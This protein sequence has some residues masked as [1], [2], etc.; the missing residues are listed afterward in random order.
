MDK[1]DYAYSRPGTGGMSHGDSTA[2]WDV[3]GHHTAKS[4]NPRIYLGINQ[5]LKDHDIKVKQKL[6]AKDRARLKPSGPRA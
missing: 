5:S 4:D 3:P 6:A 1:R 2:P